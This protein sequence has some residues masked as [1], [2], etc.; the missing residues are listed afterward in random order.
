MRNLETASVCPAETILRPL[1]R[2]WAMRLMKVVTDYDR[3][4]YGAMK[5]ALP[6]VSSK[7]L[8]EHLRHLQ[9]A[10]ILQRDVTNGSRKETFY[11]FTARGHELR[12][13]LD[14]FGAMAARWQREDAAR[15]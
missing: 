15:H 4:H 11:S 6:G 8:T 12:I 7:V 5:R 3:L 10:G 14:S 2:R 13:A 9:N 1:K